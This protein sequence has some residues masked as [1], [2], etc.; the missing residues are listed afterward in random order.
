MSNSEFVKELDDAISEFEGANEVIDFLRFTAIQ[1][2]IMLREFDHVLGELLSAEEYRSMSEKISKNA[3]RE[4]VSLMPE[5]DFR[6][7]VLQNM[8]EIF[9]NGYERI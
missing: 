2:Y 4:L 8:E 6:E 7:F 3:F 9:N 1:T 5:S